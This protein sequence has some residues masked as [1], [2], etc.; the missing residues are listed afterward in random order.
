MCDSQKAVNTSTSWASAIAETSRTRRLLPMPGEPTTPTT[1]QWPSSARVS[2]PATADMS[3]CRRT[4]SG[5][6]NGGELLSGHLRRQCRRRERQLAGCQHAQYRVEPGG[7]SRWRRVRLSLVNDQAS[8]RPRPLCVVVAVL[9]AR[10][11]DGRTL[12]GKAVIVPLP[13][14][15]GSA[16]GLAARDA[17][18]ISRCL[19]R[20]PGPRR[21]VRLSSRNSTRVEQTRD[22]RQTAARTRQRPCPV[23]SGC[24]N[25]LPCRCADEMIANAPH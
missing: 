21:F 4:R 1:A 19:R 20:F 2:K 17:A 25:Q 3:H 7:L 23:G 14:P 12:P 8:R 11:R 22:A 13:S 16:A 9:F 10:S 15:A 5:C 18:A 24:H 6:G